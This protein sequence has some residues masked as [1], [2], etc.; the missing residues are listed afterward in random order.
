MIFYWSQN[1]NYLCPCDSCSGWLD[2][3]GVASFSQVPEAEELLASEC[4][5]VFQKNGGAI[6]FF[7]LS[8]FMTSDCRLTFRC[9]I[10]LTEAYTEYT[11][12]PD[13]THDEDLLFFNNAFLKMHFPLGIFEKKIIIYLKWNLSL[14]QAKLSNFTIILI[15]FL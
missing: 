10:K 11:V 2:G 5:G 14:N 9:N 6:L 1:P 7:A 8:T 3:E 12:L 4:T 15:I 13:L